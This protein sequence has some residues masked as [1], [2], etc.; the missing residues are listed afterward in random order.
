MTIIPGNGGSTQSLV[1]NNPSLVITDRCSNG[2]VMPYK[3]EQSNS[4]KPVRN[5]MVESAEMIDRRG[6]SSAHVRYLRCR[7]AK[8]LGQLA[9]ELAEV[10]TD[11]EFAERIGQIVD[12]IK[13]MLR[14]LGDVEGEGETRE[15]LRRL[16]DTLLNGC[17]ER[18]REDGPR[19]L[20]VKI[21][22]WL[23][24]ADPVGSEKAA[25]LFRQLTKEGLVAW[26]PMPGTSFDEDDDEENG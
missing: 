14:F 3:D 12:K 4:G 5:E 21:F 10:T 17:R 8:R 25:S 23:S 16:R 2:T 6:V 1:I 13:E 18:Y 20:M 24:R 22:E 9:Y 26:P 11:N 15:L 19:K 7:E